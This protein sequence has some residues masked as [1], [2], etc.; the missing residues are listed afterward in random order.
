MTRGRGFSSSYRGSSGRSAWGGHSER[1]RGNYGSSNRGR[2]ASYSNAIDSRSKYGPSAAERYSSASRGYDDY[3]KSYRG[4]MSA[5]TYVGRD[6]PRSPERKRLRPE[7][8]Y[9]NYT[10]ILLILQA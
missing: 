1:G 5:G 3:H 9:V 10:T 4:D 8:H 6:G 7:V 2:F